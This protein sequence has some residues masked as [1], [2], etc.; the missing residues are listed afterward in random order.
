MKKRFFSLIAILFIV[1][2]Y[3]QA[4]DALVTV[5]NDT[6]YCR[7][8]EILD[9]EV[10][11]KDLNLRQD[12]VFG[13]DKNKLKV[14]ILDDGSRIDISDSMYG[15]ENYEDQNKN[16]LKTRFLAPIFN[17]VNLTYERSLKPGRSIEATLGIIGV[18]MDNDGNE[19][20]AFL[21]VGY[22]FIKSP[23]FYLKGMRYAHILKGT[24]V[25]PE[26]ALTSYMVDD[27]NDYGYANSPGRHRVTLGAVLINIGKQWVFD[28]TFILD[29]FV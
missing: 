22:K 4:Q 13:I 3:S 1:G 15:R 8:T 25:R 29:W 11:Y 7:V 26:L 17:S 5:K 18:G 23:D 27:I 6:I 28:D 10:K 12:L 2:I 20:G 24:Y 16:I 19:S 21:K 14:I 9:D